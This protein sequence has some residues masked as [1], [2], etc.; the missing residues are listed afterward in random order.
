MILVITKTSVHIAEMNYFY[1]LPD[2]SVCEFLQTNSNGRREPR[3]LPERQ[4]TGRKI[5]L[6]TSF[7][8]LLRCPDYPLWR[9]LT[10][11]RWI[12]WELMDD[13]NQTVSVVC[14]VDDHTQRM[15]PPGTKRSLIDKFLAF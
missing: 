1:S 6:S 11:E 9:W 8:H 2:A 15:N 10:G 12:V 3:R 7:R 13:E 5:D 14:G 4:T